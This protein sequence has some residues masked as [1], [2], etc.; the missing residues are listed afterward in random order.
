M[1][2]AVI[3]DTHLYQPDR[4]LEELYRARLANADLIL[5]C[6]DM[7]A[8]SVW[9]F[10]MQHPDFRA[11]SGNMDDWGLRQELPHRLGFEAGGFSIGATHGFGYG[12]PLKRS[13][14]LAFGSEYDLVCFGHTHE[15]FFGEVEGVRM[16]N[17][18]SL[19]EG[20]MAYA[21]LED[22]RVRVEF[23]EVAAG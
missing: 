16:L 11:V 8:A 14:A 12:R 2:L 20:S 10:F 13:I 22:G 19:R 23:I 1:L 18:G 4:E 17:P 6:G 5:H 3:S 9:S 15:P 21:H 7:V